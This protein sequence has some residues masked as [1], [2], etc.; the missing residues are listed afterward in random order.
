MKIKVRLSTHQ[1]RVSLSAD[2]SN[3]LG[4]QLSAYDVNNDG[5]IELVLTSVVSFRPIAVWLINSKGAFERTSQWVMPLR[6]REDVP[7]YRR[8]SHSVTQQAILVPSSPSILAGTLTVR[9]AFETYRH[10]PVDHFI[11]LP[12][13]SES[14]IFDRGPPGGLTSFGV[15]LPVDL[16]V[17]E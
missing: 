2:V 15:C 11:V 17:S 5:Q 14:A 12:N 4:L 8:S 6:E 9:Q 1:S 10:V 7:H 13:R 16:A 3:E